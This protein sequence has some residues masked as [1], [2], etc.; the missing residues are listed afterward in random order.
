M[1][2]RE[3]KEGQERMG[4]GNERKRAGRQ[5]GR[6]VVLKGE[7]EVAVRRRIT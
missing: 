6:R 5:G 7:R 1:S 4:R 2:G 3:N